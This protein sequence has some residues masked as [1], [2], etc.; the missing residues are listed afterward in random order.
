MNVFRVPYWSWINYVKER[1]TSL[2]MVLFRHFFK[3]YPLKRVVS[4]F[5][6][7]HYEMAKWI[8]P[9]FFFGS[10][11]CSDDAYFWFWKFVWRFPLDFNF[12][13]PRRSH[14]E[15]WTVPNVDSSFVVE[16]VKCGS[17]GFWRTFSS[18]AGWRWR[19]T[20]ISTMYPI[21]KDP[22]RSWPWELVT[23]G[24]GDCAERCS[25]EC[26]MVSIYAKCF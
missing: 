2:C 9:T 25:D 20:H 5:S 7:D 11:R 8:H 13:N 3:F 1:Y 12:N 4:H 23:K 17:L 24:R 18:R 21:R 10:V 15:S 19:E 6:N 16:P 26:W 14:A 22:G